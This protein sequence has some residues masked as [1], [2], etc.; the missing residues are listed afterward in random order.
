M[1]RIREGW[2]QVPNP[3]NYKQ[4]ATVSLKPDDVDV[5]VFW[6]KN[7]EPI[8]KHLTELDQRGFRYYFQFTLNDYPH[9]LEPRIPNIRARL[10]TFKLLATKVGPEKVVWRY[11]PIIISN[12][13]PVDFHLEKFSRIAD[14]L[15]RY[16]KRVMVSLVD[17]YEKT[18]RRL[19]S[20]EQKRYRFDRAFS[21]SS[22]SLDLLRKLAD[23]AKNNNI[24]ILSCA[25]ANDYSEVGVCPG[26]CI[27]D[28]LI[29]Q[30]WSIN[31]K[32]QKDAF[33]RAACHCI[34]S[35][36]IGV[37][38]TCLHGCLYCYST[39]SIETATRRY[40]EHNPKSPV[41]WGDG[42]SLTEAEQACLSKTRLL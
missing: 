34:A 7:P 26:S 29:N 3:L 13:T 31:L 25:E 38:D 41:I 40:S 28:G 22:K 27:D 19:S 33:Q 12:K 4:L 18:D 16:T 35:K 32:G 24:E 36:D 10:G 2:C 15:K 39:R 5:I 14:S 30:I 11:D 21:N 17:Y 9:I 37:N 6:T 23:V 20:L 8:L 42:R 1:N